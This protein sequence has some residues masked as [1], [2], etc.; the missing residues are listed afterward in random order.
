MNK[1]PEKNAADQRRYAA[2]QRERGFRLVSIYVPEAVAAV[3]SKSSR[4]LLQSSDWLPRE[5]WEELRQEVEDRI[6]DEIE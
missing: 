3:L 4:R 2:R 5:W 6:D 1:N